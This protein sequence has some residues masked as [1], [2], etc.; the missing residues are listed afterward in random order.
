MTCWQPLGTSFR[1]G[2]LCTARSEEVYGSRHYL[3]FPGTTMPLL[4]PGHWA[5]RQHTHPLEHSPSARAKLVCQARWAAVHP[6]RCCGSP[7]VQLRYRQGSRGSPGALPRLSGTPELGL[8]SRGPSRNNPVIGGLD[9]LRQNTQAPLV[10]SST[11]RGGDAVPEGTLADLWQAIQAGL[12]EAVAAANAPRSG[13]SLQVARLCY[14]PPGAEEALLQSVSLSLDSNQIGLVYGSSGSGKTT[15]LHLLAGLHAPTSGTIALSPGPHGGLPAVTEA[16]RMAQ[17]GLVFQFPERHFLGTT[18]GSELTFAWSKEDAAMEA[19]TGQ[20]TRAM[21]ALGLDALGP[22]ARL[23]DLSDGYKRR[24]ALAVQL[25]RRPR[26]LLLDEPLAGLDWR[27]RS[28]IV[29]ILGLVK[30]ECTV[31][32]VSH[33]LAELA[34]LV[35][36]AWVMSRGGRLDPADWSAGVPDL[37]A[38]SV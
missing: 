38:L 12:A 6:H 29:N 32:V 18:I 34:P 27:A 30:Q 26:L 23:S 20:A 10:R 24:V 25:A 1:S 13:A 31:L 16:Q 19:A 21:A 36:R 8:P 28:E 35:D 2:T 15:L 5:T 37:A 9:L 7:A 14:Q 17:V 3:P 11:D 4:V 33:D 22:E